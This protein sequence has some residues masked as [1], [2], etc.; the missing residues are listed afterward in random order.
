M[1]SILLYR[2]N[3]VVSLGLR[4]GMS[5]V[6]LCRRVPPA[7]ANTTSWRT[8]V[9]RERPCLVARK[10]RVQRGLLTDR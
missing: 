4:R 2:W 5:S 7:R 3:V 10:Q 1:I 9:G 8:R 6:S